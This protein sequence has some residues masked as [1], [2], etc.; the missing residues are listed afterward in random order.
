MAN[1]GLSDEE[2]G[3]I[4]G[5]LANGMAAQDICGYMFRPNRSLNPAG[6]YEIKSGKCGANIPAKSG[7]DVDHFI[8]NHPYFGQLATAD[9]IAELRK[10][11]RG[12]LRLQKTEAGSF[13]DPKETDRIEFKETFHLQ[14]LP[15]YAK[16]LIGYANNSGGFIL[17]GIKDSGQVVGLTSDSFKKL[18]SQK[19]SQTLTDLVSPTIRWGSFQFTFN[20]LEIGCLYSEESD[21]KPHVTLKNADGVKAHQV[22]FRYEGETAQIRAG[23]L[24]AIIR[25][26]ENDAI[27]H[28]ISKLQQIAGIGINESAIVKSDQSFLDSKQLEQV[29]VDR[30]VYKKSNLTDFDIL[31]DFI[32][33][34][35][36]TD[37]KFYIDQ[38]AHETVRWLPLFFYMSEGNLKKT[39][40]L[41]I[42]QNS[43]IAKP[44]GA[45]HIRQRINGTIT[46]YR[47]YVGAGQKKCLDDLKS[48]SIP[49]NSNLA[50]ARHLS[51][52]LIG[53][54]KEHEFTP[55][56]LRAVLQQILDD[57]ERH[58]RD[59]AI[60]SNMRRSAARVDELLYPLEQPHT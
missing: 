22:Y 4:K 14:S 48:G 2:I 26:R 34:S 58:N 21:Q 7:S 17:F 54:S 10:E 35:I 53:L 5:M 23:D 50:K 6:V 9:R 52:C 27:Q 3:I 38:S 15:V 60:G 29:Y 28:A 39:D 47:A 20:D 41:E 30:D 56:F 31:N 18:D 57:Y 42:L 40:V 36:Q 16:S 44:G 43:K 8:Q 1:R 11:I 45:K 51:S 19:F 59:S 55:A 37:S 24:M 46:A 32:N 49:Q 25:Q 12:I 33:G 13:V